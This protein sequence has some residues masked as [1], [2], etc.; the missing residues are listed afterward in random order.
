MVHLMAK[1]FNTNTKKSIYIN[2]NL[3]KRKGLVSSKYAQ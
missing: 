3:N 2:S 1:V